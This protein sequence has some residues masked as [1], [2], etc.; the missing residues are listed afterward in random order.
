MASVLCNKFSNILFQAYV[1]FPCS[2]E[3]INEGA[4]AGF[5]KLL[6]G[7]SAVGTNVI[8]DRAGEEAGL[9]ANDRKAAAI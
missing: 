3:I 6:I 2:I 4:F 1:A 5:L 8:A 9:L 7:S